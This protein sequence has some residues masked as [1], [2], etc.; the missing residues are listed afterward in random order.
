MKV[1]TFL[2]AFFSFGLI[3][4]AQNQFL[5]NDYSIQFDGQIDNH[6]IQIDSGLLKRLDAALIESADE[7][8]VIGASTAI[9]FPNNEIWAGVYGQ[10]TDDKLITPENTFAIGS[11]SKTIA[12]ACILRLVE[13]NILG[14]D[15]SLG[16]YIGNF[17]DSV[18]NIDPSITIRQCL[19]HT[20]GIYNYSDNQTFLITVLQNLTKEWTAPEVI[21]QFVLEPTFTKGTSWSYCNTNYLIIGL[22]V[23]AATG[24]AY[25][26]V[27]RE[28]VLDP[29]GFSDIQ[30]YPHESLNKPLAQL[31]SDFGN[32]LPLQ[33]IFSGAWAAGAYTSPPSEISTWIK[34][35]VKGEIL[36][37]S[38]MTEMT[39]YI[40]TS[41]TRDYGLGLSKIKGDGANFIGHSGEILYTSAVYYVDALD[42]SIAVCTNDGTSKGDQIVTIFT[43]LIEAYVG[44]LSDSEDIA[45]SAK[46]I[47]L[48]PNPVSDKITIRFEE[49]VDSKSIDIVIYNTLGQNVAQFT[50]T[51]THEIE[52]PTTTLTTGQYYIQINSPQSSTSHTFI[53]Q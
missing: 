15:D 6:E 27:V 30:L 49:W 53:K 8:G 5:N 13:D 44:Y 28:K 36:S 32:G 23:E 45:Q 25:H 20:S 2:L 10:D 9:N 31:Y 1:F 46:N 29:N 11:V 18:P 7:I 35:L 51:G 38:S 17:L 19:N 43:K 40:K 12:S 50:S 21:S 48:Y 24:K 3:L 16:M 34:K 39:D 26:E 41:A 52:I 22:V 4:E 33:G 37:D 42:I 14:L 47:N